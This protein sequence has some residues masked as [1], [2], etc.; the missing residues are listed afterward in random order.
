LSTYIYIHFRKTCNNFDVWDIH[1]FL[2]YRGILYMSESSLSW[3]MCAHVDFMWP[4]VQY[5]ILLPCV[6]AVNISQIVIC[7]TRVTCDL[8]GNSFSFCLHLPNS[9]QFGVVHMVYEVALEEIITG[10]HV[11]WTWCQDYPWPEHSG[12][13]FNRTWLPNTSCR[14][15]KMT[16]TVCGHAQSCWKNVMSTCPTL[17]M[18]KMTSFCHCYRYHWFVMVHAINISPISPCLLTAHHTVHFIG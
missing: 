12:N 5:E 2:E 11:Q 6:F 9:M 14:T 10:I 13:S 17:Q 8:F 4:H 16:F 18:T 3:R 1:N 15:S 7:V